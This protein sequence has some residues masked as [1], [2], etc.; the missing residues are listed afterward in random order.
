[1]LITN[2]VHHFII[3]KMD[4]F[5]CCCAVF[6]FMVETCKIKQTQSRFACKKHEDE[7]IDFKSRKECNAM[8][9]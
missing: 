9:C 4:P 1:M 8:H 2:I 7:S 3:L 5:L 6:H